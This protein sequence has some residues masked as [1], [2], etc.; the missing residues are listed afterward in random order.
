MTGGMVLLLLTGG[1][2]DRFRRR[3]AQKLAKLQLDFVASIS[4]EL[5]NATGCDYC[6]GQNLWSGLSRQNRF[7]RPWSIITPRPSTHRFCKADFAVFVPQKTAR[8]AITAPAASFRNT[9]NCS[10]YVAVLV[11]GAGFHVEQQVQAGLPYV[12]GDLSALSHACKFNLK[13]G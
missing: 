6:T 12:M 8:I 10:Q 9:S 3:R 13:C 4:H 2:F 7:N 11:E 5:L 1:M